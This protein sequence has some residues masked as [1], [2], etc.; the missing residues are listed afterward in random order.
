[1]NIMWTLGLHMPHLLYETLSPLEKHQI[2]STDESPSASK[3]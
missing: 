2:S 1:M 3:L